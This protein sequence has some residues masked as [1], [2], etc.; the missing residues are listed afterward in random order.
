M[1]RKIFNVPTPR[2]GC[3]WVWLWMTWMIVLM[4]GFSFYN[5]CILH[6]SLFAIRMPIVKYS[7]FLVDL[8]CY[9][10]VE[11]DF[12]E[13]CEVTVIMGEMIWMSLNGLRMSL[14]LNDTDDCVDVWFFHCIWMVFCMCFSWIL[15]AYYEI[16]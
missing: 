14:V 8:M 2:P 12:I 9:F 10:W 7:S 3:K 5:D 11:I 4:Y 15:H 16:W 1:S 6:V 13:E